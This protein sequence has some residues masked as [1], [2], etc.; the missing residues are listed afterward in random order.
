LPG[1]DLANAAA[2]AFCDRHRGTACVTYET[3]AQ[4]LSEQCS[5]IGAHGPHTF[6]PHTL[7]IWPMA[8][9]AAKQ[10]LR[11]STGNR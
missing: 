11:R 2:H 8:S 1:H 9:L 5:G 6:V 3:G 4:K 7:D 10:S